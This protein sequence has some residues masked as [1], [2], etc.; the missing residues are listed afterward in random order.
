MWKALWLAA[1]AAGSA[2]LLPADFSYRQTT[3]ISGSAAG[4]MAGRPGQPAA[5]GPVSSTIAIKGGRMAERSGNQATVIDLNA[6]TVTEID[7]SRR[8]Y[9]VASFDEIRAARANESESANEARVAV[10]ATGAVRQ[11]GGAS[12]AE[13]A[14]KLLTPPV[15]PGLGA[16]SG[17]L[18]IAPAPGA[19]EAHAFFRRLEAKIDWSPAGRLF[20]MR[21]EMA[22][23]LAA[24][25][26]ESLKPEGALVLQVTTVAPGAMPS[27]VEM[28]ARLGGVSPLGPLAGGMLGG[29]AGPALEIRTEMSDFSSDAV[30]DRE[31]A[32][33][34]GFRQIP[35]AAAQTLRK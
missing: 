27:A 13:V 6:Q 33:P 16:V 31:F 12:A 21:P 4:G 14:L 29:G 5:G 7:Y 15:A 23:I 25:F 26:R 30:G 35:S 34:A 20:A 11:I 32:I 19:T 3:A 9:S 10:Y 17:E 2:S 1:L 8:T 28:R 22:P 18:W 24:L